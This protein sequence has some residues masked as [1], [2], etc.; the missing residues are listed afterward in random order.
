MLPGSDA[1]GNYGDR[2]WAAVARDVP[3][4]T[5]TQCLDGY[6]ASHY[7]TVSRFAAGG[8]GRG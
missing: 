1:S 3:G 4:R 5:M 2:F 7:S 6:M 8:H